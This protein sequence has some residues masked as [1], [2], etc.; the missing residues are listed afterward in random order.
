MQPLSESICIRP[1]TSADIPFLANNIHE[2]CLQP[3]NHCFFDDL[4]DG[5]GVDGIGFLEGLLRAGASAWGGVEDSHILE[6]G[7]VPV[8]SAFGYVPDPEDCR[9]F[10]LSRFPQLATELGWT[11]EQT[12]EFR[13][14]YET[15]ASIDEC[16]NVFQPQA[17]FILEYVAVVP[18]ARGRGLIK[19]LLQAI[20][21]QAKTRGFASAGI[22][23]INGNDSAAHVYTSL[24]FKP[25]C[26]YYEDFFADSVPGFPG[27][28]R[29]RLRFG[30]H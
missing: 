30:K 1:A 8:A 10:R 3:L 16:A 18:E 5:L 21:A 11:P 29:Y 25:Y 13:A 7:G 12:E 22:M 2:A 20:L 23:I 9:P 6:E 27:F 4:V 28:T 14:R 17:E 26:A 15:M 19:I 24:G